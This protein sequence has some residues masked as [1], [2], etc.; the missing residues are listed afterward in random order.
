[1]S[2]GK[3]KFNVSQKFELIQHQIG[4]AYPI[5]VMEWTFLKKKIKEINNEVSNFHAIGFLLLGASAS[6]FITIFATKFQD[7]KSEYICWGIFWVT[8][9]GGVLSIYFAF[10]KNK[11]ESTKPQE[12]LNQMELIESRFES[13]DDQSELPN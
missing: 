11:Q 1:M 2:V 6:S 5:G 13:P 7:D 3:G 4:K 10:D 8:L 12:I 9:I